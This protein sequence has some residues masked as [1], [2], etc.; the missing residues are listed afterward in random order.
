LPLLLG[1]YV[2]VRIEVGRLTGVI[3]VPRDQIHEGDHVYLMDGE[4]RLEVRRVNV[5]WRD[6]N[7]V[8]VRSGLE[9]GDRIVTSRLA[10]P[11]TGTLL[12]LADGP[13]MPAD[14]GTP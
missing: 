8:L 1:S 6:E 4:G 14:G 13:S 10:S 7:E 11:V 12:R 5:A 9:A 2:E 3:A